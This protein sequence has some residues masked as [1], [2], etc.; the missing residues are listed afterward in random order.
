MPSDSTAEI[1]SLEQRFAHLTSQLAGAKDA[2]SQ[3]VDANKSLSLNAAQERAK[4]QGAGRGLFGGLLGSKFRGAMR[5]GAAASN[6]AI[7][8]EVANKRTRIADGKGK[9]QHL[10]VQIQEELKTTKQQ[11]KALAASSKD[12]A[13]VRNTNTK[14][15]HNS[16]SLLQKLKDARDAGLLTHVEF[17]EK[18]KKLVAEI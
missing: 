6:A 13:Q 7:A 17:E 3:W 4:N 11:L 14:S 12:K 8:K 18:R 16:L 1:K 15:A 10:V 9:A 5:A 2:V